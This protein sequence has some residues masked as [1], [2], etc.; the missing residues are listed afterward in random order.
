MLRL[1]R[2]LGETGWFRLLTVAVLAL[3][4]GLSSTWTVYALRQLV[5]DPVPRTAG[6]FGLALVVFVSCALASQRLLSATA[7]RLAAREQLRVLD[8]VLRLPLFDLEELGV[9]K[10]R[11]A[12]NEDVNILTNAVVELPGAAI[13]LLTA[14]TLL[15]YIAT[16]D[17]SLLA[18]TALASAPFVTVG[19]TLQFMTKA[20][21]QRF[22]AADLALQDLFRLS[23]LGAKELRLHR[24][25]R[26]HLA[27]VEVEEK[28]EARLRTRTTVNRFGAIGDSSVRAGLLSVVIVGTWVGHRKGLSVDAITSFIVRRSR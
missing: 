12:F 7:T 23:T 17:A 26:T 3:V 6:F 15:V 10:L 24:G 5:A 8:R 22:F 20:P 28:A 14:G 2:Y 13:S 27:E 11:T 25:R 16:L 21:Q 18:W 4:A 9:S 1:I 19:L